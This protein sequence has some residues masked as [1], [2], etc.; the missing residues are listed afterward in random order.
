MAEGGHPSQV[1]GSVDPNGSVTWYQVAVVW[2][3]WDV[4]HW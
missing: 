3:S 1:Q 2:R 4:D